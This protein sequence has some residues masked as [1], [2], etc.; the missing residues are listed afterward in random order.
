MF[1]LKIFIKISTNP[2]ASKKPETGE[3]VFAVL[4]EVTGGEFMVIIF[5]T[6]APAYLK[7]VLIFTPKTVQ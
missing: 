5:R 4:V 6:T 2:I 1:G 3:K 7:L